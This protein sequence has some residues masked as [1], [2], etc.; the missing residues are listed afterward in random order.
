M[1]VSV[2]NYNNNNKKYHS[3]PLTCYR[4]LSYS[5]V[6][7]ST[8]CFISFLNSSSSTNGSTFPSG[9]LLVNKIGIFDSLGFPSFSKNLIYNYKIV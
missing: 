8:G 4:I 5:I 6:T 7:F 9:D 3:L 2:I 1:F